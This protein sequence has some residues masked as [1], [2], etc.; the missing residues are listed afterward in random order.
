[1]STRGA[2][3]KVRKTATGLP[4]CTISVSSSASRR[5]VRSIASSD[6]WSRAALPLP[7]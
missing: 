1:M 5:S 7:P 2:C 6:A 3:S 4:L